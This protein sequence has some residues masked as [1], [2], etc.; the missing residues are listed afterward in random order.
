MEVDEKSKFILIERTG[1]KKVS[2]KGI[3]E[4]SSIGWILNFVVICIE[5]RRNIVVLDDEQAKL[6][7]LYEITGIIQ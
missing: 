3:R 7:N 5:S 1:R 2:K 6:V 4:R